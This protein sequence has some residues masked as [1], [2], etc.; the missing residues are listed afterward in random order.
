LIGIITDR[1]LAVRVVGASRDATDT[2]VGDVMTPNP[3]TCHPADNLD[4]TL[5]VMASH[6]IRRIPVVD[7]QGQ[8]VGIISQADIAIRLDNVDKAGQMVEQ[9]SQPDLV[10]SS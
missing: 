3:L 2:Q 7:E 5:E 8:V 6:Q 9:I 10:S 4:K 1:D